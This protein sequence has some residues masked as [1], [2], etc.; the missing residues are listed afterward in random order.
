M[1]FLLNANVIIECIYNEKVVYFGHDKRMTS[2]F[3]LEL[4]NKIN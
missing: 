3:N 2:Y 4:K 1:F